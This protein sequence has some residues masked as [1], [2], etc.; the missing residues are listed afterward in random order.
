MDGFI[1]LSGFVITQLLVTRKET[2]GIFIFRRFMR[3]FPAFAVCLVLAI[4]VRPLTFGTAASEAIREAS[5]NRF[6]WWHLGAHASL[7]HGLVPALWLPESHFAFL[8]PGWSIS[9][10]FQLYLVAPLALWIIIRF[11][12]RGVAFL[13]IGS[14][15][16]F[17]PQ[18]ASKLNYVW[19]ATGAFLPQR[20]LFFL[21]GMIMY[22][23]WNQL[24]KGIRYWH[25]FVRLGEVSY[26][27]YLVNLPRS[28]ADSGH[29][30]RLRHRVI[31]R[32]LRGLRC[33]WRRARRS[34]C[35]AASSCTDS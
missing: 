25:G 17:V 29:V 21:L 3:L 26:S 2:Y 28:L 23:H 6:F 10:E 33:Y 9:L 30:E 16:M 1:I 31:G 18:V 4:L 8:P 13:A 7:I 27:T 24:G 22:L 12:L 5:E 14:L 11:G 15:L 20:Y 19:S 32:G 35:F 34:R